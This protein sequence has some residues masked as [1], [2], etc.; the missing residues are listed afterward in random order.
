[1][2]NC[3]FVELVIGNCDFDKRNYRFLSLHS[4]WGVF[5]NPENPRFEK[6][7]SRDRG[8]SEF[9]N[10]IYTRGDMWNANE[11]VNYKFWNSFP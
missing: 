11:R 4:P 1:M 9:L 2:Y 7:F 6:Y 8:E 5:S 10:S 3:F